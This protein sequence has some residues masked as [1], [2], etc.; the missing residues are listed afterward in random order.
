MLKVNSVNFKYPGKR[1]LLIKKVRFQVNKGEQLYLCGNSGQGKSTLLKIIAGLL[2]PTAGTIRLGNERVFGP[3]F[4][5]VPGHEE[6]KLV[7]QEFKLMANHTIFEN[8][9]HHLDYYT[10]KQKSQRAKQLGSILEITHLFE[11]LPK[12]LSGGEKQ[13]VAIAQALAL[14]PKVL[15]LD[16]PFAHLDFQTQEK[17]QGLV[18]DLLREEKITSITVTH[19]PI[20][21]LRNADRIMFFHNGEIRDEGAPERLYKNPKTKE[22]AYFFGPLNQIEDGLFI[23]P[24]SLLESKNGIE[25]TIIKKQF[26]G[27]FWE[28]EI[29]NDKIKWNWVSSLEFNLNTSV[30]LSFSE[31][32][33]I[34]IT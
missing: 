28:Y 21:A 5:L 27:Q 10:A 9:I 11:K 8:I 30:K 31:A 3:K 20:D 18:N 19:H 17:T 1:N 15:L 25:F 7:N 33:M 16:E 29:E 13:R 32:K 4:S 2:E 22:S 26:A 23:R 24:E 14:P 12:E 6:I 34:R